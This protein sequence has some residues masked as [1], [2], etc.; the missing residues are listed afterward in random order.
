MEGRVPDPSL[1]VKKVLDP[2]TLALVERNLA[3]SLGCEMLSGIR[4][5]HMVTTRC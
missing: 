1:A 2:S 5:F 4:V 3:F